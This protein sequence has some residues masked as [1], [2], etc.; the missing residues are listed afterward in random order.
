MRY[1]KKGYGWLACLVAGLLVWCCNIVRLDAPAWAEE[2]AKSSAER[3][4]LKALNKKVDLLIKT[5]EGSGRVFFDRSVTEE[6]EKLGKTIDG[7]LASP[8][9]GTNPLQSNIILDQPQQPKLAMENPQQP[10][11]AN[12]QQPRRE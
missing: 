6:F 4:T 5:L 3:E 12:P 9:V 1:V 11:L 2:A 10:R 8:E 7:H